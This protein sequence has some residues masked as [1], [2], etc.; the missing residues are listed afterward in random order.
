VFAPAVS[1]VAV[2]AAQ[3]RRKTA[4]PTAKVDVCVARFEGTMIAWMRPVFVDCFLPRQCA[5]THTHTRRMKKKGLFFCAVDSFSF[6]PPGYC[7]EGGKQP[8]RNHNCHRRE[9]TH[10]SLFHIGTRSWTQIQA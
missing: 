6:S 10:T 1:L 2:A 8:Q 4:Q 5:H 9:N 7:A 3:K